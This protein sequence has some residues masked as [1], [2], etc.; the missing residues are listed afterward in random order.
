MNVDTPPKDNQSDDPLHKF[1]PLFAP[2]EEPDKHR[3]K[4]GV[5][6]RRRPSPLPVRTSSTATR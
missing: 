3:I 2:H 4:D 5:V 6:A 1:L